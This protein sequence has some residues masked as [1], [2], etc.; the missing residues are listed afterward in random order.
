MIP[1]S[2]WSSIQV[3]DRFL[4]HTVPGPWANKEIIVVQKTKAIFMRDENMKVVRIAFP[5]DAW[6]RGMSGYISISSLPYLNRIISHDF[7]TQLS[8][9][10]LL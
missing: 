7:P 2:E 4:T 8:K 1:E 9:A 6:E 10:S 3:G 5:R